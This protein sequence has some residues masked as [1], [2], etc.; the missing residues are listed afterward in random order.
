VTDPRVDLIS[1]TGSTATG[2]RIME[3][4]AATLKRLFLELGGKSAN[5]LLDDADFEALVPM[6]AMVCAHAGQGCVMTTRMLVPRSRYDAA[7]EV[8][9][10][11]FEQVPYGDPTDPANLM[12]P[13][14]SARQQERVLNYIDIG[15]NEGARLV[16]GGGRPAHLPKGYFVEP[17]LF[18]DV[19]NT[20]RVAQEEIF[21]PVLCVIAY[22]SE[23]EAIRIA[24]DSKYG[25]HS[26][27]IGADLGRARRVA[28]QIRAGRV[29]INNMMDDPQAPWGGFK[30]SGVGREYGRYGIE[31]FLETRAILE[32]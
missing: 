25:L 4:G 18:A 24:N 27:V 5:I 11:A 16:T 19:D 10:A 31:A 32:S 6:S 13:V 14:I 30:Y 12:G 7:V 21:G 29:V 2:K 23:D 3:K 17:T 22:D 1:F 28:S 15:K 26:A 9:K 20:M 8:A